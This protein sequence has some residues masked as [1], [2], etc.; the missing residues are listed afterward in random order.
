M[1]SRHERK[2]WS[3]REFIAAGAATGAALALAGCSGAGVS[4]SSR[5]RFDLI[6]RGGTILDGTGAP[7]KGGDVGIRDGR[8]AGLGDLSQS[9]SAG[10][11]I[12]AS[13]L[14][15][16]PG[17][18]D[19]H[20]HVDT[21]LIRQP[22]AE[23]KV[24]QGVTTEAS[25]MDGGSAAPLGGP[26]LE[27]YL[28]I[29]RDE[30]GFDCPYRDMD[31]YLSLLERQGIAQNL[32][33]FVGLGTVREV[34]VGLDN[35]MATGEEIAK[36]QREVREAIEQGAMGVSTGLEYTPGSFASPE[37]LAQVVAGAPLAYRIYAT[38][39]RN[40]ADTLLEAIEEAIRIARDS[41]ARLQVS[42]LKAQNKKN[43]P[44]Q[45]Q[46]LDLLEKARA[47]GMDVHADRYPYLAY[48]TDLTAL[49]P[50]WSRDGGTEKFL[51]RLRDP[52]TLA[53]IR[54]A[55]L[56]KVEG[57]GSWES[58]MIT[59]VVSDDAK[60]YQGKRI[61]EIASELNADPFDFTVE[62]LLREKARV[63][64]V[65]FG[66]NEEGTEMVLAWEHA[67]V[68]SDAGAYSPAHSTS[69]PHPRAYGT[70]PRAIAVYQKERKIVTL[71]EMIRKMTS[72]PAR[73]LGLT[74]RGILAEGNAADIVMFDY[75]TIRDRA[76][77]LDPHRFPDGI[78]CVIING[79][80]VVEGGV[81][82]DARPGRV[83]R[84]T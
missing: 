67:M 5:P 54:E 32:V 3:R 65:G 80:P 66:M 15:V 36:M 47:G 25:G 29:F 16:V 35:R 56:A 84:S 13:G 8:I 44:K 77:F 50:L 81:Q 12:D 43:W 10:R 73:K 71:P 24:R 64:M 75:A 82:T 79:V 30:M 28:E 62:L 21:S 14:H 78:S 46:A 18:I 52:G 55:V 31:G 49:F 58:V 48:S 72:L 61:S 51:A 11:V 9:V 37:E 70:F 59:S 69:R 7:A 45:R 76:T 33:T 38:H 74:D 40:E 57:L 27:Q 20:S 1:K 26:E 17:F 60:I 42:H 63:G 22:Q 2:Q 6:I 34:V 53:R 19:I 83:L 4:I 41:G 23:S 39:M 68:A